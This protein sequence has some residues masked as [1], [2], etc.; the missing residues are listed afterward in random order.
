MS[1]ESNEERLKIWLNIYKEAYQRNEKGRVNIA[2]KAINNIFMDLRRSLWEGD[3]ATE[4]RF[5]A[6]YTNSPPYSIY[7]Q[8]T[9]RYLGDVEELLDFFNST[10]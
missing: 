10:L 4:D 7:V 6:N 2:R 9:E 8:M 1:V 3:N 5:M